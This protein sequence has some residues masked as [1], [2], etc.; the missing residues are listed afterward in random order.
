[1]PDISNGLWV[2]TS[3]EDIIEAGNA[4]R[5][6]ADT[7][8]VMGEGVMM[9]DGHMDVSGGH[10]HRVDRGGVNNSWGDG[11]DSRGGWG[12][13]AEGRAGGWGGTGL[14]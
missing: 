4:S 1:M 2:I 9:R 13:R 8:L 5:D 11:E 7:S 6:G 14:I 12:H 3:A 10:R